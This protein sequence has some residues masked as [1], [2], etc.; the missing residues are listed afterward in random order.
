MSEKLYSREEIEHIHRQLTEVKHQDGTPVF[1]VSIEPMVYGC[2]LKIANQDTVGNLYFPLLP[3]P[4][5]TCSFCEET[6]N[7]RR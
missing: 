1:Q 5:V 6:H 3:A 7:V 4:T 2:Y